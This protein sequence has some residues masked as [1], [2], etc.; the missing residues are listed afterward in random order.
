MSSNTYEL[1]LAPTVGTQVPLCVCQN[2]G[3]PVTFRRLAP[4]LGWDHPEQ[5]DKEPVCSKGKRKEVFWPY[6][7]VSGL[8]TPA[9]FIFLNLLKIT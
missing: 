6:L 7:Q 2:W 9:E 5:G 1:G 4:Y 3:E 8:C